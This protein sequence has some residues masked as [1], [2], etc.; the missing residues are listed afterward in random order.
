MEIKS[1]EQTNSIRKEFNY[2][3]PGT[4]QIFTAK[5]CSMPQSLNTYVLF[6]FIYLH[7]SD[8][9]IHTL[10]FIELV[11]NKGKKKNFFF[12]VPVERRGE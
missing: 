7:M 3:C 10:S 2:L 4:A 5:F 8:L 6:R 9:Y 12:C 1:I 11:K